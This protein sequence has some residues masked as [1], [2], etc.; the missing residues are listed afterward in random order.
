[1]SWTL[2]RLLR[3]VCL[4]CLLLPGGC[5]ERVIGTSWGDYGDKP[6]DQRQPKPKADAATSGAWAIALNRIEGADRLAV[7]QRQQQQ[8]AKA[9]GMDIWTRDEGD[10]AV[11]Y[12]GRYAGVNDPNAQRDLDRWRR[13]IAEGAVRLPAVMLVPVVDAPQRGGLPDYDLRTVQGR[14]AYTLQIGYYDE[15]FGKNFRDAAEQAAA[16]LRQQGEQAFYYHGPYRSLV[17]IGAWPES[18]ITIDLKTG[19]A[20]YGAEVVAV[21]KRFPH[22]LGNGLTINEKRAGRVTTQDSFLVRIPREG[23]AGGR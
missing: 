5:E 11:V 3:V 21:Q 9:T 20:A 12:S 23:G 10:K 19:V 2:R 14:E 16:A 18:A 15:Q 1:M 6:T 22:N 17:T 13:M 7:A 4:L 8:L